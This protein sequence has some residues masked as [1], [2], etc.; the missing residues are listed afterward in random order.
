MHQTGPTRVAVQQPVV[1]ATHL[2]APSKNVAD[3]QFSPV[4]THCTD[5][6]VAPVYSDAGAGAGTCAGFVS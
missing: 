2:C 1:L 5:A 3:A 6:E 4:T